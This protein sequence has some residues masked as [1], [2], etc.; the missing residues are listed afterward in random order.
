MCIVCA[1]LM[2]A[3]FGTHLI[4]DPEVKM[5]N[6][7]IMTVNTCE[8]FNY[9]VEKEPKCIFCNDM[10]VQTDVEPVLTWAPKEDPETKYEL[11]LEE[12]RSHEKELKRVV[13]NA[14]DDFVKKIRTKEVMKEA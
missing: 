8:A 2:V 13:D 7:C 4:G 12:L 9:N 1:E 10:G 14:I 3:W 5:H 11:T 6:W